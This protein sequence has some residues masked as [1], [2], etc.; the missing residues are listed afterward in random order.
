MTIRPAIGR[1][2]S[3]VLWNQASIASSGISLKQDQKIERKLLPVVISPWWRTC[4]RGRDVET[5]GE[6][7][8][9]RRGPGE[10]VWNGRRRG[11]A[12]SPA[13]RRR[14]ATGSRTRMVAGVV[15]RLPARG[16]VGELDELTWR[17]ASHRYSCRPQTAATITTSTTNR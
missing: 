2:L 17:Y 15:S 4:R 11:R 14:A 5:W 1:F 3:V 9:R 12:G 16:R 6:Q 13:G 7:A 10:T 8:E